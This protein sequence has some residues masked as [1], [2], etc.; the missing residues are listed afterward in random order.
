MDLPN[1]CFFGITSS[2]MLN[3]KTH[4]QQ[5]SQVQNLLAR[6]VFVDT[7]QSWLQEK[8]HKSARLVIALLRKQKDGLDLQLRAHQSHQTKQNLMN[9]YDWTSKI[10]SNPIDFLM[11]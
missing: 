11:F 9:Q 5:D 6:F 8:L 7:L 4:V 2:I 10:L 3:A 1:T